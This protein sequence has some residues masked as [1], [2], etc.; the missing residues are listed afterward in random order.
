VIAIRRVATCLTLVV[1]L[2]AGCSGESPS[3]SETITA[4]ESTTAPT[5]TLAPPP[6]TTTT[7]LPAPTTT[8]TTTPPKPTTTT[9]TSAAEPES[10]D[11][12]EWSTP[13]KRGFSDDPGT[14][15]EYIAPAA[16]DGVGLIDGTGRKLLAIYMV[17]SDL[18]DGGNYGTT[19]FRE[20]VAGYTGLSN[21]E[22][23]E[24]V[25]AFGGA[26]KDGWRGMKIASGSQIMSDS[27]DREFGNETGPDAYLYTADGANMGD[28]SSL[29]LFLDYLRD[30]YVNFDQRFLVFWDHGN[31][32]F[33]FGGDSNFNLD[34]LDMD[35]IANAFSGS[36]AGIFDLIGFD[37]CLMA[38]VEVAK[39]IEPHGRYMIASEELEPGHGWLWSAVVEAFAEEDSIVEAGRR[40]V[41]NFVL[42]VHDEPTTGKTLSLL[43]LSEYPN[44]VAAL[45]PVIS[46]L[47]GRVFNSQEFAQGLIAAETEAR[48]YA[49]SLRDDYRASMD[50]MHFTRLLADHLPDTGMEADLD[51]LIDAIDR[52]VVHSAHDGTRPDSHGVAI[53][54]P[55]LTDARYSAYKVSDAWRDFQSV[56][57]DFRLADTEPPVIEAEYWDAEG[58]L[59]AV[60][61]RYLASVTTMY[62]FV[63]P[64]ENQDGTVE[65]Y[66][67]VVAEEEAHATED[68]DVYFAP[69]WSQVWFTVEYDPG[70]ETAWIPAFLSNRLEL[71]G[72][73]YI[74]FDAYIDYYQAG[75]DY[76]GYEHPYDLARLTLVVTDDGE[77]WE[78]SN[79]FIQTYQIL[80][81]GPNDEEGSVQYDRAVFRLS[82]GD[83]VQFYNFGFNLEDSEEDYWF[84]TADGLVTLVQE[85]GFWFEFL[86]FE[87]ESGEP[88]DYY[89]AIWAE[90]AA[91]NATLGDLI[92]S[93]PAEA[94]SDEPTSAEPAEVPL[95]PIF[96]DPEGYFE[97]QTPQ[98]WTEDEPDTEQTEIFRA[99]DPSGNGT[100]IVYAWEF[101][102]L[103][104]AEYADM[105]EPWFIETGVADLTS[106]TVTTAQGVPAVLFEGVSGQEAFS[107]LAH[108]SDG[109]GVEVVYWFPIDQF[110]AGRELAFH[111]FDTL[112]VY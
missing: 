43:D 78:I 91:G 39:V 13:A 97:V 1:A 96:V 3:T 23:L 65:D 7:T 109:V 111:S 102:G 27:V 89:Y 75:K 58:T 69:A 10:Q 37:A 50:L 54:A 94:P 6:A 25:V 14:L 9:T 12:S 92:P 28:E 49:V 4:P 21:P 45:D 48:S 98:G 68:E 55:E 71:G 82:P 112:V 80:Y 93:E 36:Q 46:T 103:S 53:D 31:T 104:Q 34:S 8:T 26:D 30:G 83:K 11:G 16:V 87:D 24:I 90:D 67:M 52:F 74:L 106:E 44:L 32:Y 57:E 19:D 59:A 70:R 42:D 33:G 77:V 95:G 51:R 63:Q 110:E 60:R 86:E 101:A 20:L 61:D 73:E 62:G 88:E 41:D 38:T 17:G 56:Y 5:T 84:H 99:S 85:P 81:T 76:S 18:E 22:D 40:M 35:E 2:L 108:V 100:V 64:I 66:F 72:T 15:T 105:L 79:H 29:R 47:T 107:W